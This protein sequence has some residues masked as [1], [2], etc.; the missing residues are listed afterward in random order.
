[1]RDRVGAFSGTLE[2][3]SSPGAGTRVRGT[4]PLPAG[5]R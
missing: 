2:V 3:E 1:M 4:L 5:E